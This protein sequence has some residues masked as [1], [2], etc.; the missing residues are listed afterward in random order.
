MTNWEEKIENARAE[1]KVAGQRERRIALQA[2]EARIQSHLDNV[3]ITLAAAQDEGGM[4]TNRIAKAA[5]MNWKAAYEAIE[6]GR[7]LRGE[8]P[9]PEP[10]PGR[11]QKFVYDAEL[12]KLTVDLGGD[13]SEYRSALWHGDED[14]ARAESVWTFDYIPGAN[15]LRPE[16]AEEEGVMEKPIVLIM[17]SGQGRADA[18]QFIKEA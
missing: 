11:H 14:L 1:W 4:N 12:R 18:I 3:C 9:V 5:G 6:R 7:E 8:A 13:W 10:S 16:D 15:V 2:A 17:Q